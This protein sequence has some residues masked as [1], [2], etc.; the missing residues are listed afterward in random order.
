MKILLNNLWKRWLKIAELIGTINMMVVLAILY[1]T[2]IP[3]M[4]IPVK[5]FKDPLKLK[6]KTSPKWINRRQE[7]FTLENLRNQY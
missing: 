2:L 5:M 1:L 4:A 6:S 7:S 3:I